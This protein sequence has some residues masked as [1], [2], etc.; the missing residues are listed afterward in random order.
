MYAFSVYLLF[1]SGMPGL[2]NQDRRR[3][4]FTLL[5]FY[6]LYFIII[7]TNFLLGIMHQTLSTVY[8]SKY[9]HHLLFAIISL[10]LILFLRT[11]LILDWFAINLSGV[12]GRLFSSSFALASMRVVCQSTSCFRKE[13][14]AF[15]ILY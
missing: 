1:H 12:E 7:L 15:F 13:I 10:P 11:I 5:H 3:L 6:A 8:I 14:C 9:C 2:R 4:Y